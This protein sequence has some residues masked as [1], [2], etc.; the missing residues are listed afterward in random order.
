MFQCVLEAEQDPIEPLPS[1]SS[2]LLDITSCCLNLSQKSC[3]F[4]GDIYVMKSSLR[5]EVDLSC[6]VLWNLLRLDLWLFVTVHSLF[7][8]TMRLSEQTV[9]KRC[10]AS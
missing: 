9:L 5:Y 3:Q 6:L 8:C 10:Y 7:S 2:L 4:L 1:M